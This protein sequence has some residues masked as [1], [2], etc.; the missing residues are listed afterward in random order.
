MVNQLL[1]VKAFGNGFF[2]I[3]V[4]FSCVSLK[5]VEKLS[6]NLLFLTEQEDN[7]L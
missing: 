2:F 4:F 3:E 7:K 5:T 6:H 1:Y